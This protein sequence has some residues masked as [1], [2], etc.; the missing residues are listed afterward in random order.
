MEKIVSPFDRT[1]FLRPEVVMVIGD[2]IFDRRLHQFRENPELDRPGCYHL[3]SEFLIFFERRR[4]RNAFHPF[5][6]LLG[7]RLLREDFG[8]SNLYS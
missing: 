5:R 4:D 1:V 3:F 6:F 8:N 2:P 7:L